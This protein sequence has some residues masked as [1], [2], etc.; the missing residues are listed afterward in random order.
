MGVDCGHKEGVS[1]VRELNLKSMLVLP[2]GGGVAN[3]ARSSSQL[4]SKTTEPNAPEARLKL[5]TGIRAL[6]DEASSLNGVLPLSLPSI[7]GENR[8]LGRDGRDAAES[9]VN[10]CD[11]LGQSMVYLVA[12]LR[13]SVTGCAK[14]CG[15]GTSKNIDVCTESRSMWG[16]LAASIS[17]AG[18]GDTSLLHTASESVVHPA[19]KC[20]PSSLALRTTD[21]CNTSCW[22]PQ[23]R[24]ENQL[25]RIA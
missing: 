18:A 14:I 1:G 2:S 3:L 13:R 19:E 11:A 4:S 24:V 17:I 6:E 22:V 15:R 7:D 21:V 12:D 23:L 9:S 10:L 25:I 5:G 16:P 20:A 8:I